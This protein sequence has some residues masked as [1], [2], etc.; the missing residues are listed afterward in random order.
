MLSSLSKFPLTKYCELLKLATPL[1]PRGVVN[2]NCSYVCV[3]CRAEKL[4]LINL[5][6]EH[7]VDIQVMIEEMEERLTEQEIDDI[8]LIITTQIPCIGTENEKM[9]S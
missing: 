4:H 3:S 5:R 2:I 8:L 1:S 9:E 7:P 6:P